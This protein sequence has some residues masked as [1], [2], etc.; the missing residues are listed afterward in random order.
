MPRTRPF[1][2]FAA[3]TQPDSSVH[4]ANFRRSRPVSIYS[5]T[6]HIL[7]MIVS[8]GLLAM[9]CVFLTTFFLATGALMALIRYY[10][11]RACAANSSYGSSGNQP[12]KLE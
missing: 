10:H 11:S 2:R 4:Y 1:T 6:N 3:T 9:L 8:D 5:A 12:P 7:F